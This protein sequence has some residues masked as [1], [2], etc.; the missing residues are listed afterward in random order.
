MIAYLKGTIQHKDDKSLIVLAGPIGY[1]V[2]VP[3]SVIMTSTI[4]DAIELYTYQKISSRD[5]SL[6]M[7]GFHAPADLAFFKQLIGISGVG[8]RSAL[9][10]LS[11]A[12]LEELT[13][14]IVQGD[15]AL[16][17]KV[18]GIGKKTAERVVIELKDKLAAYTDT[19]ATHGSVDADVYAALEGLGYET[20]D[21]REV[22]R[23]IPE[24]IDSTEE[25]IKAA[26]KVL[27][28]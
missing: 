26:L 12:T 22:L 15:S 27:A 2:A 19:A 8:P 3:E 21:V 23:E 6:E 9:G 14:T 7:F 16:L 1:Q 17:T 11:V 13:R 24:D 28:K 20:S 10:V 18:A 4:G 5:E 25:K